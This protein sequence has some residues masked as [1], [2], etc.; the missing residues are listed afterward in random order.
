MF[1][2][3]TIKNAFWT[4]FV[5][6]NGEERSEDVSPVITVLIKKRKFSELK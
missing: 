2:E 5:W 3:G 6:L 1:I 4:T